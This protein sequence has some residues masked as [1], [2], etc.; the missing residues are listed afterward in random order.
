MVKR[1]E[2]ASNIRAL[3]E[4]ASIF[5]KE[6]NSARSKACELA[7]AWRVGVSSYSPCKGIH[8]AALLLRYC[9]GFS[10]QS[11]YRGH[12]VCTGAGCPLT[13]IPTNPDK[14][15]VIMMM[16]TWLGCVSV[17]WQGETL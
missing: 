5:I 2:G 15:K 11:E 1:V 12:R 13:I 8:P 10:E 3:T 7:I 17:P 14:N 9:E 6:E 4:A 16:Y